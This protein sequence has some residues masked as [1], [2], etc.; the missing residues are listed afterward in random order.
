MWEIH[1]VNNRMLQLIW[2]VVF[3]YYSRTLWPL[4]EEKSHIYPK[5]E[6]YIRSKFMK[7]FSS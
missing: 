7:I 4:D 6:I 3:A 5:I 1:Y 2:L